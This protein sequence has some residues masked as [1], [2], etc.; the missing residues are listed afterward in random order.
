MHKI[1]VL[2]KEEKNNAESVSVK[3]DI[4]L[5][6]G[7]QL[8]SLKIVDCY[9]IQA[10]LTEEELQKTASKLFA[11]PII[12]DYFIDKKAEIESDWKIEVKFHKDV[13]DNKGN[14]AIIG[15]Q[16]L[17]KRKFQENEEIRTSKKYFI[18]GN[19]E[20]NQI[21]RICSELLANQVVESFEFNKTK[22]D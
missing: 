20:E 9:Y 18:S 5:E 11:D 17:I 7:I 8:D 22:S 10:E 19:V 12:Q 4:A 16:D 6:L 21:K 3:N 15:V 14:A 13:T 1:E 2:F